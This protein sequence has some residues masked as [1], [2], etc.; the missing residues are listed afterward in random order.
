MFDEGILL[1]WIVL[2]WSS[3]VPWELITAV[4]LACETASVGFAGSFEALA[5]ASEEIGEEIDTVG[6]GCDDGCPV[7]L[8]KV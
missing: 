5:G 2:Y 3:A 6:N 4:A 7:V 1:G 8:S